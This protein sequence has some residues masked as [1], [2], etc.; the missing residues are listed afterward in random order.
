MTQ[1]AAFARE[2]LAPAA[3]VAALIATVGAGA[4]RWQDGSWGNNAAPSWQLVGS[5]GMAAEAFYYSPD[6]A[7]R[8]EGD[9]GP[10][11][12]VSLVL[13]R[14]EEIVEAWTMEP[15]TFL[16][17]AKSAAAA[18]YGDPLECLG[19][20]LYGVGKTY[21]VIQREIGRAS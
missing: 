20:A 1:Q 5:E 13:Y 9:F 10:L 17:V 19:Q 11:A 3:W 4:G 6:N 18:N 21:R 16:L 8:H 2:D 15:E 14:D 7:E 12:Y